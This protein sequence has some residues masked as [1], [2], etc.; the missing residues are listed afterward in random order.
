ML[1]I[2]KKFYLSFHFSNMQLFNGPIMHELP[3]VSL[4]ATFGTLKK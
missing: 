1:P 4:S 2:N 3:N